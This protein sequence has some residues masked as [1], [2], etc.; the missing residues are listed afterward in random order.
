MVNFSEDFREAYGKVLLDLKNFALKWA[1]EED[2]RGPPNA[3]VNI[4]ENIGTIGTKETLFGTFY[5]WK[6][7][8][9]SDTL[10]VPLPSLARIIPVYHAFWNS[11][12]SGSDTTTKLMDGCAM[13]PPLAHSN[14]ETRITKGK[15]VGSTL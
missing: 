14:C 13:K 11:L 7:M 5:L 6:E 9:Y 3:I 4:A 1:Y 2:G 15:N 10:T 8:F 12:K